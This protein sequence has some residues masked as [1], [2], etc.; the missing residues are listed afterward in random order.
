MTGFN[1]VYLI[2]SKKD[3]SFYI[4]YTTNLKQRLKDHNLENNL[5]TKTKAPWEIVYAEAYKNKADALGREQFLKSGSG[6][7]Y[8]LKQLKHLFDESRGS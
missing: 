8:L 3:H 6:H 2:I 7:H 5:S 4:G 1:Y